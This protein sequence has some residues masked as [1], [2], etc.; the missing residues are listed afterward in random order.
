MAADDVGSG[1]SGGFSEG[2]YQEIDVADATGFF[3]AT[4]SLRATYAE[5]VGFVDVEQ[6]VVV[7]FLQGYQCAQVASSPSMLKMLSVTRIIRL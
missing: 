3:G 2:A 4:Q 7:P 1:G 6:E 5:G